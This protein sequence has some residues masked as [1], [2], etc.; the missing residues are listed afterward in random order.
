MRYCWALLIYLLSLTTLGTP[1][2]DEPAS[3]LNISGLYRACGQNCLYLILSMKDKPTSLA[4]IE[5]ILKPRD[6]GD[7]TIQE[8][9]DAA[10]YYGLQ[11]ISL[12]ADLEHL[13]SI[14]LPAIIQLAPKSGP[15]NT[16]H[17][18]VL[19]G[20][21]QKGAVVIDA[22]KRP[23]YIT[24]SELKRTWTGIIVAF[25]NDQIEAEHVLGMTSTRWRYYFSFASFA[26]GLS[27][28]F[29]LYRLFRA[30]VGGRTQSGGIAL[31][32]CLIIVHISGI[33]GC[34]PAES[35]P[36][37]TMERDTVDLGVCDIGINHFDINFHNTGNSPLIIHHA[38]ASCS[39]TVASI[40]EKP[41][42]AHTR[43]AVAGTVNVKPGEGS[44]E[45]LIRTNEVNVTEK[46]VKLTWFGKLSPTLS[47][48][49]IDVLCRRG[50][51]S[52]IP[53]EI[54]YPGGPKEMTLEYLG[55][56]GVP[57]GSNIKLVSNDP[58]SIQA[59][60]A[61]SRV[62][63]SGCARFLFTAIA[64]DQTVESIQEVRIKVLQ[65]GVEYTLPLLVKFK[66]HDGI[67]ASPSSVMFQRNYVGKN[68]FSQTISSSQVR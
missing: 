66:I 64:P 3:G 13:P 63:A 11:T 19:A 30:R 28:C 62:M 41:I 46:K 54:Y 51:R 60:P 40:P 6:N 27:L 37:F 31:W 61:I 56:Q 29:F 1:G 9:E 10:R 8:L 26:V 44:A 65:R 55:S 21:T 5:K 43:G 17:Y 48:P 34:M 49:Q 35:R 33:S 7:S 45:V 67:Q 18:I 12:S 22:P 59:N 50:E 23:A 47:V 39:C 15:T 14:P 4:Q 32:T 52:E 20:L 38:K 57:D 68:D 25:P 36:I 53:F 42:A 24:Y 16:S 2:Q 58:A